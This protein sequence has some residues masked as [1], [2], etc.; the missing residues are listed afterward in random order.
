[1]KAV[2]V[3]LLCLISVSVQYAQK[4]KPHT[5][6][7]LAIQSP[8]TLDGKLD[9]PQWSQAVAVSN[10]TQREMNEGAP[11]TEETRVAVLYTRKYLFVGVWCFD[12]TPSKIIARELKRDFAF[13]K[14][15]NFEMIIDT[16][17]DRRNG[18][19][20]VT[21][22]NGAKADAQVG[23]NGGSFNAEW[24][25]I[26][27]VKARTTRRGWFAEFRIPFA[28]LKFSAR[29][30][31]EWG[32]NFERNV[33]RKKEQLLWQGW[34]RVSELEQVARAGT[35]TGLKD[36]AGEKFLEFRPYVIAGG[37]EVRDEKSTF[38]KD[39]GLDF[40]YMLTPTVK[41]NMT[42]N[43]D[44]ATAESDH[45]QVN[46]TRF[47]I[48]YPEKREFFLDGADFFNFNMG[49]NI[50][51]F[52]SRRI[53]LSDSGKEV[54]ILGGVRLMGKLGKSTVGGLVIQEAASDGLPSTNYSVVRW[55]Q[56]IFKQSR[57]GFMATTR[58][59]P[60]HFNSLFG[61][62]FYYSTST[63][64]SDKNFSVGGA[65]IHSTTS[66][67]E[68][69]NGN[70]QRFFF[71]YPNDYVEIDAS[72]ERSSSGFNPEVG[73][74][75]RS[76]FQR[77]ATEIQFNP[78]PKF[79]PWMRNMELKPVD[80]YY[81]IDNDTGEMQSFL[82]EVRPMG[83]TTRS[84]EFIEFN[85]IHR[86]ENL[87]ED[88]DIFEGF[89]IPSGK[90]WFTRYDIQSHTYRGRSLYLEFNLNWGD[91]YNGKGTEYLMGLTWRVSK[92]FS[93]GAD[94]QENVIKLPGGEFSVHE[95]GGRLD[96][97]LSTRLFGSVFAQWNDEDDRIL[98]NFRMNWIPKPG[99]D[100]FLIVNH[101]TDTFEKN[102]GKKH[103]AVLLKFVWR[104]TI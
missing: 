69:K 53:G 26:W 59:F 89:V 88:F 66:D 46:L 23:D 85:I 18:Y 94:F 72:W 75:R 35:L 10:F 41:L 74:L 36:I 45:V 80:V 42:V 44:F 93:V 32:I 97:A 65:Y 55:S 16:Y 61:A 86:G 27:D 3:I 60:G 67:R 52:Y 90:Y 25:G 98:L 84:G 104:F 34:A 30:L 28:T 50:R 100:L 24:D 49:T 51:P 31:Q 81:Y 64:F 29:D 40:S 22:P 4:S 20:F 43:P 38:I 73:Y 13:W 19:L 101:I 14:E 63:L 39:L 92:H 82:W 2:I 56:D 47:S 8:I 21:N 15:D 68:E 48:F 58:S 12:K 5:I 17:R 102:W 11:P 7:A 99:T 57:I 62:D 76:N 95:L 87:I 1:M 71:S 77:F 37:Q 103:L 83:F 96:I 70:A 33:R 6:R 9:E 79:I 54:P 91:F 78:R